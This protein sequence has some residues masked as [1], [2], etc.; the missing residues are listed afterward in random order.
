MDIL[1]LNN[2]DGFCIVSRDSDFT[3]LAARLREAG[4]YVIGM[5]EKKT[6][7]RYLRL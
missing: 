4:M 1:S 3:M 7:F 6:L 5:G 2:V